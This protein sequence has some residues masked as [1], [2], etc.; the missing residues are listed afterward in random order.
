MAQRQQALT[1]VG[2]PQGRYRR[3]ATVLA[4]SFE[5]RQRTLLLEH[6][7]GQKQT[8]AARNRMSALGQKQTFAPHQPMSAL[9][10]KRQ[11]KRFPQ[12]AMSALPL[13][14][15]MCGATEDVRYG[16]KRTHALHYAILAVRPRLLHA[17]LTSP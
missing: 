3:L 10:Q 9:P 14:A 11:Q 7:N 1:R 2:K 4:D 16:P 8:C 6:Y 13:K 12:K 5:D 17:L 15:D